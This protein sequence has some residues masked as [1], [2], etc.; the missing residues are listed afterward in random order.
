M[1]RRPINLRDQR[2]NHFLH[3]IMSER[4]GSSDPQD[5]TLAHGISQHF[6]GL[7]LGDSQGHSENCNWCTDTQACQVLNRGPAD[8]PQDFNPGLQEFGHIIRGR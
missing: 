1:H 8:G 3:A 4:R 2:V 6:E 7:A 5:H